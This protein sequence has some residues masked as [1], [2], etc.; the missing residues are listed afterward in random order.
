MDIT[1][2]FQFR[3]DA[4]TVDALRDEVA[5]KVWV[6]F[7]DELADGFHDLAGFLGCHA[8]ETFMSHIH[9]SLGVDDASKVGGRHAAF[10]LCIF[11][12]VRTMRFLIKLYAYMLPD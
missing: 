12:A 7:L 1:A 2:A 9:Q 3:T 8:A 11:V 10:V 6:L 5:E 4:S